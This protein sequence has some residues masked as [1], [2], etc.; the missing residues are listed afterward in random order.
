MRIR[1]LLSK[2]VFS[3][4]SVNRALKYDCSPSLEII[5]TCRNALSVVAFVAASIA[6]AL[7]A[8]TFA[9]W[10]S[11][12]A[13]G[14]LIIAALACVIREWES[15]DEGYVIEYEDAVEADEKTNLL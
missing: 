14:C 5:P 15:E 11:G 10:T 9:T 1:I 2:C 7:V 8:S 3:T 4:I 6:S 12:G 13:W